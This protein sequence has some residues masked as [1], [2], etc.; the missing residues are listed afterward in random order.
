MGSPAA[1]AMQTFKEMAAL[2]RLPE[3]IKKIDK[4]SNLLG[5]AKDEDE[6]S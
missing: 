3:L 6:K 2:R 4:I 5:E 1:D